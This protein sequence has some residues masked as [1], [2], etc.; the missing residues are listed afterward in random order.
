VAGMRS[1]FAASLL[2]AGSSFCGAEEWPKWLG[3]NGNNI[4]SEPIA[5]AW[6]ADGPKKLWEQSTGYGFSS[7]I[8]LD[9]RIYLF[10]QAGTQDTLTAFDAGSGKQNWS[11]AYTCGNKADRGNNKNPTNEMPVVLATPAIDQGKIFTYG[12]GGDLVCRKLEDGS[13]VWHINVVNELHEKILGWA[14]A[15][16]PLVTD[17][18]VYVQGGDGGPTAVAVDRETGKVAWKSQAET[19]GGYAAPILID[20]KGT[21][22]LIIFGGEEL[23]GMDPKTG[24]TYWSIPFENRP[25]V[26]A[27]T[28]VYHDGRLFVACDYDREPGTCMMVELSGKGAKKLW[29]TSNIA[30]KFQPGVLD[31]GYYYTNSEGTL[32]CM[33]WADGKIQ[34]QNNLRLGS[35]GSV[36]RDGDKLIVMSEHG[37]LALVQATPQA[38]KVISQVQLLDY[39]QVWSSPLI[40][41]GKLYCRGEKN[42][43]CLDISS[44][45]AQAGTV[46]QTASR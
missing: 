18:L 23:Y 5:P 15:S 22:Q 7:P 17:K 10:H 35:G 39:G 27:A 44:H 12:A 30:Q 46:D 34:W 3:P 20:V 6:P 43:V 28:P 13:Q 9:G 38:N 19:Q 29:E 2:L 45:V 16:S 1:W 40:Y 11:Q 4:S 14:E 25:K 21:P 26:S 36:V 42:L 31:N 8:A 24:K 32:K 41:R 37:K 33:N